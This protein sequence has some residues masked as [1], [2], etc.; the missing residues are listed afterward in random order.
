MVLRYDKLVT[1]VQI[2]LATIVC[3]LPTRSKAKRL[4]TQRV[5][6][7]DK[8]V[9][10]ALSAH[11]FISHKGIL[12]CVACKARTTLNSSTSWNL[13]RSECL[14]AIIHRPNQPII[15]PEPI[16]IGKKVSHASH[17]LRDFRGIKFCNDCGFLATQKMK[18]LAAPCVGPMGRTAHGT[19]VL[20][21]IAEHKVPPGVT[22]WPDDS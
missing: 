20:K 5:P 11:N 4:P 19:N 10:I 16:V 1:A 17:H 9:A 2:R 22:R 7:P 18:G 21:A 6:K 12:S 8:E 15:I 14:P 13:I 3:N